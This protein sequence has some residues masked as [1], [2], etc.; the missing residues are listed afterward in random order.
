MKRLRLPGLA[1]LCVAI[2][3]AAFVNLNSSLPETLGAWYKLLHFL[4]QVAFPLTVVWFLLVAATIGKESSK[5]LHNGDR[6]V[7]VKKGALAI[8]ITFTAF[9]LVMFIHSASLDENAWPIV[10]VAL[11]GGLS[12]LL[13]LVTV[14]AWRLQLT[15]NDVE[16]QSISIL[17]RKSFGWADLQRIEGDVQSKTIT[18]HFAGRQK[19]E[20]VGYLE[21]LDE[22]RIFAKGRLNDA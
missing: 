17:G 5:V 22:L 11:F 6:T 9:F 19:L 4:L 18:L 10:P 21:A 20:V 1:A 15:W 14:A 13:L 16:I 12:A 3:A 2:A 8:L 7:G